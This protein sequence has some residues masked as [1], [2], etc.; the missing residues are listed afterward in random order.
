MRNLKNPSNRNLK[1]V[2]VYAHKK[3]GALKQFCE[4]YRS[5]KLIFANHA[6]SRAIRADRA[7]FERDCRSCMLQKLKKN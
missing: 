1:H 6:R 4:G 5:K 2:I 7:R 3:F